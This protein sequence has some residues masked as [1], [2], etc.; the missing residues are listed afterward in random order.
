MYCVGEDGVMYMFDALSGQLENVLQ[1]ADR[2]VIGVAHHPHR[3]LLLTITD[4]GELK[5]WKP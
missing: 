4:N 3:N 5:L 2:E 1:V